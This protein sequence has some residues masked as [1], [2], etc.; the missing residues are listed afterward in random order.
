MSTT[1]PAPA[2][3]P[4]S[5]PQTSDPEAADY[6]DPSDASVDYLYDLGGGR[7]GDGGGSGGVGHGGGYL[8]VAGGYDVVSYETPWPAKGSR[9]GLTLVHFSPQRERDTRQRVEEAPGFRLWPPFF[10]AQPE[11]N[12]SLKL[13]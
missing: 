6:V 12:L 2:R 5:P 13:Y 8:A 10:S 9:Q 4:A 11:P 3:P 7:G 1:A